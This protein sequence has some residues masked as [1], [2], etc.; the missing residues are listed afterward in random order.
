MVTVVVGAE[1]EVSGMPESFAVL[2]DAMGFQ[3]TLFAAD[4]DGFYLPNRGGVIQVDTPGCK[5]GGGL[6]ESGSKFLI[7]YDRNGVCV[8]VTGEILDIEPDGITG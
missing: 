1:A 5:L 4:A 2:A 7:I 8:L 3:A 6:H